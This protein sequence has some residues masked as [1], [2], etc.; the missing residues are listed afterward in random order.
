MI[1]QVSQRPTKKEIGRL[2]I[3]TSTS[4]TSS[5]RVY[6]GSNGENLKSETVKSTDSLSIIGTIWEFPLCD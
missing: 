6:S 4:V 5:G 2:R 1:W 3:R